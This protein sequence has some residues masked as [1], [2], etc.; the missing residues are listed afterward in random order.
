MP[1]LVTKHVFVCKSYPFYGCFISNV[2]FYALRRDGTLYQVSAKTL[3]NIHVDGLIIVIL[4][5]GVCE[6]RV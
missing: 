6:I 1:R 5:R 2:T 4:H 3:Q